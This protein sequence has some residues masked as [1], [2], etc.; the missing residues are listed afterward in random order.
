MEKGR[1]GNSLIR[2]PKQEIT[3]TGYSRGA[4]L[5]R[6]AIS[7]TTLLVRSMIR[8]PRSTIGPPAATGEGE[9]LRW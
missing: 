7:T 4:W 6:S 1:D 2:T 9:V 8:D 3:V 5:F